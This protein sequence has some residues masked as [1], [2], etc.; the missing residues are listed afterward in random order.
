LDVTE[1]L[2]VGEDFGEWQDERDSAADRRREQLVVDMV[3][4]D[5]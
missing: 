4:S 3:R 5:R 1:K 2:D